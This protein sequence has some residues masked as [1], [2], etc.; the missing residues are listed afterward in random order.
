MTHFSRITLAVAVLC[1]P[2]LVHAD[3][4]TR[5]NN[6]DKGEQHAKGF[7]LPKIKMRGLLDKAN[8][9]MQ[10][11]QKDEQENPLV[12]SPEQTPLQLD[13]PKPKDKDNKDKSSKKANADASQKTDS[14]D[15]SDA[16]SA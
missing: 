16:D 11:K 7:V 12:A 14:S 5:S 13:P 6:K 4:T 9:N 10:S 1:L 8:K 3:D 2:A 15:D